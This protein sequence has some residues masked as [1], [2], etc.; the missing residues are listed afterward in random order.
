[1]INLN[2]KYRVKRLCTKGKNSPYT[3]S[4]GLYDASAEKQEVWDYLISLGS[5]CIEVI[6]PRVKIKSIKKELALIP[7]AVKENQDLETKQENI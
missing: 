6:K 4:P 2:I 5:D 3:I 1:M 7:E